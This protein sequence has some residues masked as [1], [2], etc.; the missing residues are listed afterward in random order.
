MLDIDNKNITTFDKTDK[1]W[2]E[3]MAP[4]N[5]KLAEV[6]KAGSL[7]AYEKKVAEQAKFEKDVAAAKGGEA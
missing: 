2:L 1:E 5:D 3:K 6:E 7:K 4:Y